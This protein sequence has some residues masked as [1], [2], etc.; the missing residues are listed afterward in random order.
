MSIADNFQTLLDRIAPTATETA[1]AEQHAG[2]IK[3]RLEDSFRLKKFFIAGGYA[4][5]TSINH[6]SDL[7][8]FA[9][10]SRDEARHGGQYVQSTTVLERLRQELAA[11]YPST[12]VRRDVHAIVVAFAETT[13]DV[14]PAIFEGMNEKNRPLYLMPDGDGGWMRTS[15]EIHDKYLDEANIR[16][17]S[18][19][20]RVA[21]L[22]KFWRET[23]TPRVPISS[24]HIEMLLAGS[25]TC[26][27]VKN[28]AGCVYET[29][30][31]LADRKC[32][33]LRDPLGISNV[34]G[35]TRSLPQRETALRSVVYARDHA[36]AALA[37]EA[38]RNTPEARRQWNI[39]FNGFFPG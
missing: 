6:H 3:R 16:S 7:D 10:I 21:R 19:L 30:Q 29:F 20:R 14:V 17:G 4:R 35:A 25:D 9:L 27:G 12:N 8:L 36:R 1:M 38:D 26:V 23:R 32:G 18:K 31:I 33:G 28:Y 24:F 39:V 37:A 13:V 11:R 22:I 5:G 34:I 2:T 15:P